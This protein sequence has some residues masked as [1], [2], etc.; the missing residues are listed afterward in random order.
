MTELPAWL[1]ARKGRR[2]GVLGAPVSGA[3]ADAELEPALRYELN[4]V[5]RRKDEV[6][7]ERMREWG[8]LTARGDELFL[9]R[10]G[11]LQ[12]D[13]LVHEFF[14]PPHQDARYA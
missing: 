5:R 10:D 12:V 9:N 7:L 13:R 2:I 6:E 11:L 4:D 1:E 3:E 8:Y 14:L